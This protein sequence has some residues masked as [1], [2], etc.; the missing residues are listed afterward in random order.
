MWRGGG[1]ARWLPKPFPPSPVGGIM[2]GIGRIAI[3]HHVAGAAGRRQVSAK[4]PRSVRQQS[5]KGH[6]TSV[7][8]GE[9]RHFFI[10]SSINGYFKKPFLQVRGAKNLLLPYCN[11]QVCLPLLYEL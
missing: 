3:S 2:P 9:K 7:V 6:V 4:E 8:R 11:V 10:Y 1:A 5:A